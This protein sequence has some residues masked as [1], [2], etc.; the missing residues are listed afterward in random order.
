MGFA[1]ARYGARHVF[2]DM[3]GS[4]HDLTGSGDLKV[5]RNPFPKIQVEKFGLAA[6]AAFSNS[7]TMTTRPVLGLDKTLA[8]DGTR[9]EITNGTATTSASYTRLLPAYSQAANAVSVVDLNVNNAEDP[10]GGP[11]TGGY[12]TAVEGDLLTAK[13]ITS[14]VGGTQSARVYVIFREI[15]PAV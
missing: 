7:A 13:I 2:Y 9:A 12:P 8:S 15:E 14:G 6:A 1:D 5:F 4:A 10:V 3:F 11:Q